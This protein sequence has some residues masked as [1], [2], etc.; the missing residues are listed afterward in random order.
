MKVGFIGAGKVGTAFG[1]FLINQGINVIGYNNRSKAALKNAIKYTH[2]KEFAKTELINEADVIFITVKDDHIE[3]VL[4]ESINDFNN[5]KEKTF[6]HMSGVH[7]S[8]ILIEAYKKGADVY[9]LHPLQSVVIIEKAVKDFEE[10]YFSIESIGKK[11]KNIK[12]IIE[13]IEHHFEIESDQKSIYHM[14]A[15]V[16]S[17]YLT[18]LMD[19][20]IELTTSIGIE[21][22]KAFEAMLPLINGTLKNIQEKGIDQSLTGPLARGDVKTIKTHLKSYEQFNQKYG[23]FYRLM[24]LKTL[25]YI[26]KN[27]IQKLDTIENLRSILEENH[28]KGNN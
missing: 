26:E 12:T 1:K 11:N 18:T 28:E 14:A 25:D 4:K 21:Q 9:A 7:S 3:D 22:G 6:I 20:G 15:C 5:L 27:N 10:T 19:F 17:N 2:T 24:G 23:D 8:K 13:V 16:F